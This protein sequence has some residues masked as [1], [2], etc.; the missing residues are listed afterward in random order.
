M[1]LVILALLLKL[2]LSKAMMWS[3]RFTFGACRDINN[4]GYDDLVLLQNAG[5]GGEATNTRNKPIV[6]LNDKENHLV[7]MDLEGIPEIPVGDNNFDYL[8]HGFLA[9]MNG[10]SIE[11]LVYYRAARS[12]IDSNGTLD[13]DMTNLIRIYWGVKNLQP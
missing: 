4:D 2:A 9:D 5:G 13:P 11:D 6:Y 3:T 7:K 1:K 12:F 8:I 10:D